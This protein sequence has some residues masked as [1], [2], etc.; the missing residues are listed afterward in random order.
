MTAVPRVDDIPARD[1]AE[2]EAQ[3]PAEHGTAAAANGGNGTAADTD[4]ATESDLVTGTGTDVDPAAETSGTEDGT[5]TGAAGPQIE[6]AIETGPADAGPA[7][8][9]TAGEPVTDTEP[10]DAGSAG[11]GAADAADAPATSA[12]TTAEP[13]SAAEAAGELASDTETADGEPAPTEVDAGVEAP[14]ESHSGG[15]AGRRAANGGGSSAAVTGAS[16][17]TGAAAVATSGSPVRA[18]PE[19]GP[20]GRPKQPASAERTLRSGL[21]LIAVRRPGVP[22]VEL[23]LRVPFSGTTPTLPARSMLLGET[24]LSGTASRSQVE[25]AAALQTLGAELHASVDADRLLIGG[26]VLRTGLTT[27]LGLLAE[28]LTAASY[29]SREV[30]GERGRLV[31]RLSIARSQPSVLVR[32][33]LR[34]RLFG[35]HPYAREL[36]SVE[37]VGAVSA[38]Q[39]RRLHAERVLPGGSVLVLVG[40][41]SPARVLDQM[42]AAL[43]D[44]RSGT[45]A[46]PAPALP[47]IEPGPIVLADRPGSVQTSI[48]LGGSAVNRADPGYPALQLVNLAFGGNFSSRLVENIRE[49]KGYTYGPH[50]RIDHAAA[51]ST[52]IIDADVATGVTAPALLEIWY[53]LGRM[54]T[55][56]IS[57]GEL[58]DVRQY[59]VG[60]LA[61]SVAS[62]SGL[63][64]TLA[65]LAGHGLSLDWLREHPRRLAAVTLEDAFAAASRYLA[66][67]RMVTVLLGDAAEVAGPLG[68]LGP[69][70]SEPA[71]PLSQP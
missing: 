37:D 65:A 31:E 51:G 63:A 45:P 55:L 2:D 39:L 22:L 49:D 11:A 44:W 25:L 17:S 36:P 54:A 7:D 52:L 27:V 30:A 4:S 38:G 26:T 41:V 68:G 50:S 57:A 10:A 33:A 43:G 67:A 69:V 62:Q 42:E 70:A 23:R 8:A 34:R 1:G 47:A 14:A 32:E 12:E 29:P 64:S 66:P 6:T 46:R 5:D 58:A 9:G 16:A 60:T 61:L 28:V 3:P 18:V 59:A 40:D 53:E 20:V 56:P 71:G 15:R 35:N 48:R 13:V 24:L 19:L 21:R